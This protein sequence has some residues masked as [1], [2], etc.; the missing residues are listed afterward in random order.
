[1]YLLG[2]ELDY[3]SALPLGHVLGY[4]W[5]LPLTHVL[6]LPWWV[7]PMDSE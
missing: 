4:P 1:M 6:D 5:V 2:F 3:S 7:K